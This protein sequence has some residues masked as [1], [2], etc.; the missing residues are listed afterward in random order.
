MPM[1]SSGGEH[2]P[3]GEQGDIVRMREELR[4]LAAR[5]FAHA[6]K[7]AELV[8]A[9]R[10]LDRVIDSTRSQS[11]TARHHSQLA[12]GRPVRSLL[13]DALEDLDWPAYT[14]ELGLYCQARYGREIA[15]TR[16]GT[17]ATDETKSYQRARQP[18]MVWL[19]FAL[20]SGRAE[21]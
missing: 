18:R 2:K 17:L 7:Q 12:R 20:T 19:C 9:I 6:D 11:Q 15:P 21:S 10:A 8:A 3:R 5:S 1:S 4:R 16:F 13:L 14:R